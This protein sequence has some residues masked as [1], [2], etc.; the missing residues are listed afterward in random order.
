MSLVMEVRGLRLQRGTRDILSGVDIEVPRGEMLALMGLS[1]S[2]TDTERDWTLYGFQT[3]YAL[4]NCGFHLRPAAGTANGVHPVPLGFSRVYVQ[5]EEPFS[6]G[7]SHQFIRLRN[8]QTR[9]LLLPVSLDRIRLEQFW[10]MTSQ[11][12][13][14][15]IRSGRKIG[16]ELSQTPRTV[17]RMAEQINQR[18]RISLVQKL[19][20]RCEKFRPLRQE[21]LQ[22]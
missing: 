3:Y 13:N 6:F 1:G 9:N 18:K 17:R 8:R 19:A 12:L 22:R 16:D 7:A 14:G 20:R 10:K 11:I 4:L 2:G 5:L 15:I 21:F